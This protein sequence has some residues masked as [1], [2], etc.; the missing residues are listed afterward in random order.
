MDTKKSSNS[1]KKPRINLVLRLKIQGIFQSLCKAPGCWI[2]LV[3]GKKNLGF[4]KGFNVGLKKAC[5]CHVDQIVSVS[6][7]S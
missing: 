5:V 7:V 6:I 3:L 2:N 1:F 4:L